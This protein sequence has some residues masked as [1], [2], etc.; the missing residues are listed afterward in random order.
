[1]TL[2]LAVDG[3][4]Q[5]RRFDEAL[6]LLRLNMEFFPQSSQTQ[7]GIGE[8]YR[9][10]GDTAAAIAAYRQALVL[11]PNDGGARQRLRQLGQQP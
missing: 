7:T 2:I 1:M 11:N 9:M 4:E 5:A 10:R 6:G 3:L 8:A